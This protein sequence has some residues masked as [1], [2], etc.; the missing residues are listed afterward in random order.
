MPN[1]CIPHTLGRATIQTVTACEAFA[2]EKKDLL[3]LLKEYVDVAEEIKAVALERLQRIQGEKTGS[4]TLHMIP[5]PAKPTKKATIKV[6]KPTVGYLQGSRDFICTHVAQSNQTSAI[7]PII[8][9]GN[10]E[11]SRGTG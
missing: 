9:R 5:L 4:G 11:T 1:L 10:Q 7:A 3:A 8:N 2:L 6:F